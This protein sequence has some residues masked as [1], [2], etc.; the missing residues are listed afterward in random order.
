[1]ISLSKRKAEKIEA[2]M[3]VMETVHEGDVVTG[4]SLSDARIPS[5]R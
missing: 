5:A 3:K 2:W 1:M 4:I